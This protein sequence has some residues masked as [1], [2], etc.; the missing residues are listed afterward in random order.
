MTRY[1]TLHSAACQPPSSVVQWWTGTHHAVS[2]TQP[3]TSW[4]PHAPHTWPPPSPHRHR[5]KISEWHSDF[6]RDQCLV[7][8]IE[9]DRA[10][11]PQRAISK[12]QKVGNCKVSKEKTQTAKGQRTGT[13]RGDFLWFFSILSPSEF[14]KR[15]FHYLEMMNNIHTRT[16]QVSYVLLSILFKFQLYPTPK[17][18]HRT[19]DYW[20][21][22]TEKIFSKSLKG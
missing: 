9:S 16:D 7:N 14:D 1:Y 15:S 6:N 22:K 4:P 13:L 5:Y 21:Q 19:K 2:G 3:P 20:G 12:S 8:W 11:Y 17:V 10:I 18:H